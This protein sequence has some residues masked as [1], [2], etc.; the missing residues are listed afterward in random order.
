MIEGVRKSEAQWR[1]ELTREQ[2]RVC[3]QGGT[4][5]PFS[6]QYTDCKEPGTYRCI[7]CGSAL[8]NSQTKFDSGTGWPSFW[9]PISEEAIIER[10]DHSLGLHR[11][12]ALCSSC[13]AHL[14]HV[15][16]DGP[17]PTGRRYC[18]NSVC[19]EFEQQDSKGAPTAP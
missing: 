10:P 19:L 12:E 7:C 1:R 13:F 5:P 6:G 14:G 17:E 8:F 2:Y 18:I 15:F 11:I 3:R 4:E 9:A 16:E